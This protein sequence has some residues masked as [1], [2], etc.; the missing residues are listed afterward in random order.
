MRDVCKVKEAWEIFLKKQLLCKFFL[1][2]SLSGM[3]GLFK[4]AIQS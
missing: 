2:E 4:Y 1:Q 3:M